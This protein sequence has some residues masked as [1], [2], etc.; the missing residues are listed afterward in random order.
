MR[1]LAGGGVVIGNQ[2]CKNNK[3]G[4]ACHQQKQFKL[5][6]KKKESGSRMESLIFQHSNT[7]S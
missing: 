5:D 2:V 3:L 1:Y 6:V 4:G 7:I